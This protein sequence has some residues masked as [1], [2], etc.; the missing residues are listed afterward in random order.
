MPK[1]SAMVVDHR[2]VVGVFMRVDATDDIGY[3]GC[4]DEIRSSVRAD[5]TVGANRSG[6]ATGL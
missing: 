6:G 2:G 3:F 1:Q 4:H 5:L